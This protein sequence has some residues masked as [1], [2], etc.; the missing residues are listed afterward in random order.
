MNDYID[1]KEKDAVYMAYHDK[2]QTEVKEW[3]TEFFNHIPDL[4][5]MER[6]EFIS[7]LDEWSDIDTI[8]YLN[9]AVQE[10][11]MKKKYKDLFLYYAQGIEWIPTE[12]SNLYYKG[13]YYVKTYSYNPKEYKKHS[14][15]LKELTQTHIASDFMPCFCYNVS[16]NN[17][18]KETHR[19]RPEESSVLKLPNR[20]ATITIKPYTT[21]ISFCQNGNAYLELLQ[22]E[23][24][25][26]LKVHNEKIYSEGQL[27]ELSEAEIQNL[28]TKSYIDTIDLDMLRTFYSVIL[29]EYEKSEYQKIN[30]NIVLYVPELLA[31]LGKKSNKSQEQIQ[32]L[33][34]DI[35]QYKNIVGVF[36]KNNGKRVYKNYYSLLNF[37][38]YDEEHNTISFNSPYLEYI[39][40]YLYQISIRKDAKGNPKF[41]KTGKPITIATHSY[42]IKSEIAKERNRT[43]VENVN[44][45]VTLIEQAGKS[46]PHISAKTIVERNPLLKQRL[47][48]SQP[49]NRQQVLDRAFKKTW[50]LL[51]TMTV[52]EDSYPGIQLPDPKNPANYP[53]YKLLDKTVFEFPHTGKI[54]ITDSETKT[55]ANSQYTG[56]ATSQ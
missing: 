37:N 28:T 14:E 50:E 39:T 27:Q 51:H 29:Q 4:N 49:R 30:A 8:G 17:I 46:T 24:V 23:F 11:A 9:Q 3:L 26:K 16:F 5:G 13:K 48:E 7:S 55:S 43:A 35:N 53:R 6:S 1:G 47:E 25:G 19:T 44:I 36:K 40:K 10:S 34:K 52:I 45:I 22:K 21:A 33:I 12:E 54:S 32:E 18:K 56:S 42:L 20:Q 2:V 15:T 41:T 38:F 31:I